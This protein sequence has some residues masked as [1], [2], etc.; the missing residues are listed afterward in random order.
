M[1]WWDKIAPERQGECNRIKQLAAKAYGAHFA[2]GEEPTEELIAKARDA[3]YAVA[4]AK[5]A[6]DDEADVIINAIV[7][8]HR[9][10]S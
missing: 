4:I 5:D 10:S 8:N 3:A 2:Y 9:R 7:E 1:N 6:S